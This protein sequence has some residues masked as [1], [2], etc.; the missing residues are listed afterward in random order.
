MITPL[1]WMIVLM[2]VAAVML[3]ITFIDSESDAARKEAIFDQINRGL[4]QA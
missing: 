1:D 2:C 3:V 4:K